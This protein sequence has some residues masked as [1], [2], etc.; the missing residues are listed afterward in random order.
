MPEVMTVAEIDEQ[1]AALRTVKSNRLLG[2]V[3]SKVGYDGVSTETALA[4]LEEINGEIAR[5]EAV[6][7]RISGVPSG[8]GPIRVGFGRRL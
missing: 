3:R 5:L 2:N 8:N 6:R 1:L 4:S 7:A